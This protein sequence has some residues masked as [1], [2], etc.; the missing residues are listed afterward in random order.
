MQSE[1]SKAGAASTPTKS[2]PDIQHSISHLG[3]VTISKKS[4]LA[5]SQR[6]RGQMHLIYEETFSETQGNKSSP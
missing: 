5:S 6:R 1:G 3:K 2:T 4:V